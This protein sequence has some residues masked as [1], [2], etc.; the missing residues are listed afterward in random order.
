LQFKKTAHEKNHPIGQNLGNQV[1]L[2]S[3]LEKK[4][5]VGFLAASNEMNCFIQSP[6]IEQN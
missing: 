1:T 4:F 3:E 5:V 2:F 6:D